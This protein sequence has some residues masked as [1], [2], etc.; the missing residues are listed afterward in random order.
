[1]KK[2][3]FFFVFLIILF[4]GIVFIA[5]KYSIQL[6]K[7]TIPEISITASSGAIRFLESAKKQIG[8]VN[9]YDL[10]N[11]YYRNGGYPPEDTGVCSDVIWR[12]YRDV[13]LDFRKII[14]ESIQK[15]PKLYENDLDSNINYR[16]V[17]RLFVYYQNNAKILTNELL[18]N[19][20]E[21]LATWQPG[22]IVIFDELPSSH[23]WHI[24]IIS[25]ERR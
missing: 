7:S 3:I 11:G 5:E 4:L 20:R 14:S 21:N 23:L 18:P 8:K 12:A 15:N 6:P 2:Y 9:S 19:K 17:K 22:D 1:M 24:G 13:G 10:T 25:D 16:R